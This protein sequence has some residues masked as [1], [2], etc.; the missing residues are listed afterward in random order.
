MQRRQSISDEFVQEYRQAFGMHDTAGGGSLPA[1]KLGTVLRS[2]GF[3]PTGT[4]L[5]Q[6]LRRLEAD[7][8]SFEQMCECIQAL[9]DDPITEDRAKQAFG[10]F[11]GGRGVISTAELKG[12]LITRGDAMSEAEV[13]AWLAAADPTRSGMVSREAITALCS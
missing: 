12:L 4:Q 7:T 11:D 10:F 9:Q 13:D 1:E 8:V 5:E 2:L 3:A 6:M